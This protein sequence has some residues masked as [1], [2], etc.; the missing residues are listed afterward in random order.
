M[1]GSSHSLAQWTD[2]ARHTNKFDG[3][4]PYQPSSDSSTPPSAEENV[5]LPTPKKESN[6]QD[7][8]NNIARVTPRTKH[9]FVPGSST[10][11]TEKEIKSGSPVSAAKSQ[12][13]ESLSEEGEIMPHIESEY[14]IK[15]Y[16][17]SS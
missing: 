12:S 17:K 11:D 3:I 15:T 9:N 13:P 1:H 4:T 6:I 14:S 16:D 7:L 8:M 2:T 10:P 5:P